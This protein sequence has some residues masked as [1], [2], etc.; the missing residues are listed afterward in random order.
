M[1]KKKKKAR[2]ECHA[3]TGLDATMKSSE[4][5]KAS[6]AQM[7]QSTSVVA[8]FRLVVTLYSPIDLV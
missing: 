4:I 6:P 7:S 1:V 5:A 2:G 8:A 3:L